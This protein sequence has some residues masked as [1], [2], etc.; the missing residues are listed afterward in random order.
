[1]VSDELN[2]E[3]NNSYLIQEL[4]IWFIM[5]SECSQIMRNDSRQ[6]SYLPPKAGLCSLYKA[7]II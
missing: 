6:F 4:Y 1:M 7:N 2:G 5:F 3:K